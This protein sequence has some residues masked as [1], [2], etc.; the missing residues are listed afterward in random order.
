MFKF[1]QDL[2]SRYTSSNLLVERRQILSFLQD[3]MYTPS[4]E[5]QISLFCG[6][7][8][9]FPFTDDALI[10]AVFSFEPIDRYTHD[11]RVKPIM[12][13]A[14]EAQIPS[15]VT[16][17]SKGNSSVFEQVMIP[18]MRDGSLRPLVQEIDRP[19]YVSPADFQKLLDEPGWFTWNMLTLDLFKKYG[20]K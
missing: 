9:W 17:K 1:K 20:I 15:T 12:R 11:H 14:L 6:Q 16:R 13:M 7:E 18:W 4:L 3:G 5:R 8:M 2:L 10:E 19:G